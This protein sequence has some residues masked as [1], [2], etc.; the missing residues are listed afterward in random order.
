MATAKHSS[1]GRAR[2]IGSAS[3]AF[4]LVAIP[5]S[6]Y[7]T[8]EPSHEVHFH[9][10]HAGCGERVKQFYECPTHGKVER[11]DLAKGYQVG[12]GAKADMIELSQDELDALDAV[13]NN[14]IAIA[15]FVPA[16][17][18]DP[19]YVDRTYYLGPGRGGDRAYRLLRD[20]LVDAELVGIA[21]YA[22][23]GKSY[24]VMLRP[25]EDGLAMHQLRYPD[26]VK[27]WSAIE[28]PKLPTPT[29][30]E[31]ALAKQVVHHLRRRRSIRATT[32]TRSRR[33]SRSCSR[34]RRRRARRSSRPRPRRSTSCPI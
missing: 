31:L 6:V 1:T 20:A 4:G 32:P 30:S 11:D 5:V 8:S 28:L 14:E 9:L 22:A 10:V 17:A 2:A 19:I 23:R 13:A 29:A 24:V 12:R 3:I 18:V 15:E 7:S 16:T 33:A 34:T 27:P 21:R 26:E 25:F